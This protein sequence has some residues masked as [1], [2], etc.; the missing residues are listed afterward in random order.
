[1]ETDRRLSQD[2]VDEFRKYLPYLRIACGYSQVA[3]GNILEVAHPTYNKMETGI[4]PMKMRD[5]FAVR[6]I[7]EQDEFGK[8]LTT[9]L[10]DGSYLSAREKSELL[11]RMDKVINKA[12]RK[13]G[14]A[15]LKHSLLRTY[16]EFILEK[17]AEEFNGRAV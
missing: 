10:V 6:Y 15:V 4:S 14:T 11:R 3:M 1:M 12:S 13:N 7:I 8:S 17:K 9:I 16:N 2:T 5:Y